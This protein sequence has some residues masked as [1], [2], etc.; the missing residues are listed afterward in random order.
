MAGEEKRAFFRC[1]Q[2]PLAEDRPRGMTVA[3]TMQV[4]DA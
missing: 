4:N 2:P 1:S 3:I